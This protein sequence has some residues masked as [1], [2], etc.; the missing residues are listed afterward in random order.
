[1]YTCSEILTQG[2][3]IKQ[4]KFEFRTANMSVS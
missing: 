4:A 1:M 2:K 3:G